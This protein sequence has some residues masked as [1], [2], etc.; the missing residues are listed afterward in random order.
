[1]NFE[2]KLLGF[3]QS[4]GT[5]VPIEMNT[6]RFVDNFSAGTRGSASTEYVLGEKSSVRSAFLCG[7]LFFSSLQVLP[8]HQR[9]CSHL[10]LSPQIVGALLSALY[11]R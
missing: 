11:L 5:T 6:V 4:G 8:V 1:M 2:I 7:E 3:F 9:V 10:L